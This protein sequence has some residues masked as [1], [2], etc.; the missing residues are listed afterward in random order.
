MSH[1]T[2]SKRMLADTVD[3]LKHGFDLLR[4]VKGGGESQSEV[5]GLIYELNGRPV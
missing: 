3:A 5:N 2:V 1:C 4:P